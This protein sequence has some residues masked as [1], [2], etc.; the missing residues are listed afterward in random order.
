[1][2]ESFFN[3]NISI[4]GISSGNAP[5]LLEL[6]KAGSCNLSTLAVAIGVDKA[7]V[8]RT[9][10][11]LAEKGFVTLIREDADKRNITVSLTVKGKIVVESVEK[12]MLE[13]VTIINKGVTEEEMDIVGK[14]FDTFYAN[15]RDYFNSK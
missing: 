4:N 11:S 13:W 8:T 14:V 9:T 10:R 6:S 1:M 5:L 3:Q 12:T 7:Y 2:G 15:G